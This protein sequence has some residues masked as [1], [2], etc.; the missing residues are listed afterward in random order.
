MMTFFR[1][2]LFSK[3]MLLTPEPIDI[4]GVAE[5]KL[6]QPLTA[7][8]TGARI[9]I[10]ISSMIEPRQAGRS[11][12]ER[13]IKSEFP[14]GSIEA[15]LIGKDKQQVRLRYDANYAYSQNEVELTLAAD[16]GVP[17]NIEFEKL[18]IV[19]RIKLKSVLVSW[20]NYKH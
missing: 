18:I 4:F 10:N 2:L 19:S 16:G 17:I 6:K 5:F 15:T 20:R 1:I 13:R 12:L 11:E 8:T 3:V 7:I 14:V 9:E